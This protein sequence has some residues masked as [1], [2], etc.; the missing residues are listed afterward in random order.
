[1]KIANQF[2]LFIICNLTRYLIL[3]TYRDRIL[4]LMKNVFIV[5]W[6]YLGS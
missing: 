1:M 4:Y 3:G 2:L 5:L 6:F